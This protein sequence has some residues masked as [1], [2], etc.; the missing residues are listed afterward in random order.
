MHASYHSSSLLHD[1]LIKQ[2]SQQ[3]NIFAKPIKYI[4][5]K[6][7]L[8]KK[9]IK[10]FTLVI[11]S[12]LYIPILIFTSFNINLFT[13][14]K[15]GKSDVLEYIYDL[16]DSHK[17][18]TIKSYSFFKFDLSIIF[19]TGKLTRNIAANMV[20]MAIYQR[21]LIYQNQLKNGLLVVCLLQR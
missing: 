20:I 8:K 3:S 14:D 12:I 18:F 21:Y 13:I 6:L 10:F 16:P 11:I 2:P 5:K 15:F 1:G 7:C 19:K 17:F 9:K 4:V